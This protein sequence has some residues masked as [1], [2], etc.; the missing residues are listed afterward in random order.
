MRPTVYICVSVLNKHTMKAFTNTLGDKHALRTLTWPCDFDLTLTVLYTT[1]NTDERLVFKLFF[2]FFWWCEWF[3]L[4]CSQNG[5]LQYTSTQFPETFASCLSNLHALFGL[6]LQHCTP[7]LHFL[8]YLYSHSPGFTQ[9]SHFLAYRYSYGLPT[10]DGVSQA[11]P[12]DMKHSL[13][14]AVH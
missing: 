4:K 2:Y 1:G 7:S 12:S 10:H 11:N 14:C 6:H 13:C 9:Y 5:S 3:S 8:V